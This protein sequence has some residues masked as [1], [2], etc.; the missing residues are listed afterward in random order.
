MLDGE[1]VLAESDHMFDFGV[2]E[3][4]VGSCEVRAV[5]VPADDAVTPVQ[6]QG[7]SAAAGWAE[8]DDPGDASVAVNASP[9]FLQ[10]GYAPL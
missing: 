2:A 6:V 10:C 4:L 7:V 3:D 1:A 8:A 9:H 5:Y